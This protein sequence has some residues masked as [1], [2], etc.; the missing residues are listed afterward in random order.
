MSSEIVTGYR[1]LTDDANL[2]ANNE[3]RKVQKYFTQRYQATVFEQEHGHF[4][5]V[6]LA[7]KYIP[8]IAE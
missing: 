7:L 8:K 4:H 1:V 5:V 2:E 3:E 6:E